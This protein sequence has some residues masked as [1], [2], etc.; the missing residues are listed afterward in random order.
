[1]TFDNSGVIQFQILLLFKSS[2]RILPF[3]RSR[4][5]LAKDLDPEEK[6]RREEEEKK[7]EAARLAKA[8][9]A[10]GDRS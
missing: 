3:R 2:W 10:D 5:S 8:H 7:R 4:S 1:M 6:R 9:G